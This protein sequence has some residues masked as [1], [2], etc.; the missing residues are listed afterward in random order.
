MKSLSL[1]EKTLPPFSLPGF[2]RGSESRDVMDRSPIQWWHC[3]AAYLRPPLTLLVTRYDG[4]VP[5]PIVIIFSA[6]RHTRYI[7]DGR[8]KLS[9]Q[10]WCVLKTLVHKTT[11]HWSF[12]CPQIPVER[13]EGIYSIY[14]KKW[15]SIKMD[16]SGF[17]WT[18]TI[19]W[20][21]AKPIWTNFNS[22]QYKDK[23]IVFDA[24]GCVLLRLLQ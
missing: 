13:G 7:R 6:Y 3:L 14:N 12:A 23:Y 15:K 17:H 19:M 9:T 8:D 18:A 24:S 11:S 20:S 4:Q 21:F 1:C 16:L 22:I 2:S 5:L 10:W